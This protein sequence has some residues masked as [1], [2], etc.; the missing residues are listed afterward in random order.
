MIKFGD[1]K[2]GRLGKPYYRLQPESR[3]S[4]VRAVGWECAAL[5]TWRRLWGT[6]GTP[7]GMGSDC[8]GPLAWKLLQ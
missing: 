1:E 4:E 5:G 2:E 6:Q 7:G 3:T 8:A